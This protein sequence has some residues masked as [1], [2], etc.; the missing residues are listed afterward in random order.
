MIIICLVFRTVV[1]LAIGSQCIF[2]ICMCIDYRFLIIVT[3]HV[4]S[5]GGGGEPIFAKLY[6]LPNLL[7]SK[8]RGGNSKFGINWQKFHGYNGTI[9]KRPE[10]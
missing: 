10:K 7:F 2:L 3:T 4:G 1:F 9:L 5:L 6:Q 8:F